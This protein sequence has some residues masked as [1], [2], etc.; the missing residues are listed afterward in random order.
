M[1][2]FYG[3]AIGILLG[4]VGH[5]IGGWP[6]VVVGAV[7]VIVAAVIYRARQPKETL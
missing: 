4:A 6:L 1:N 2:T 7:L 3:V 5:A